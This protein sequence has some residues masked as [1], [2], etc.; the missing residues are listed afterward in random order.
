MYQDRPAIVLMTFLLL[1]VCALVSTVRIERFAGVML[2]HRRP[3]RRTLRFPLQTAVAFSWTG[4]NGERQQG[5]GRS[6][7]LSEH[8]AFVFAP[9]CPPVGANVLLIIDLEG[10]PDKITPLPVEVEGEVLRI[11]Q[12]PSE[13]GTGGFAIRY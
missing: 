6:R 13:R 10:I 5:E 9:T 4:E 3:A 2:N 7:D 8:G 1:H 12:Y 11:E